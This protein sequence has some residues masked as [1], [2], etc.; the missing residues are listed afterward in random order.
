MPETF[1]DYPVY[2]LTLALF[3][4]RDRQGEHIQEGDI[5]DAYPAGDVIGMGRKEIKLFMRIRVEGWDSS[6]YGRLNTH[7]TEPPDDFD[8]IDPEPPKYDKRRYCVPLDRLNKVLPSLDLAKARDPNVIHQPGMPVDTD[9]PHDYLE[10]AEMRPLPIE[11]LVWDKVLGEFIN[12][13]GLI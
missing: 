3:S 6:Q 11:G 4:K 2:E 7:L 5:V 10:G 8:E 9:D 13:L 1:R 12:D